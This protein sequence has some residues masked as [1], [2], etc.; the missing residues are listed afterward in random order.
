MGAL[1][2]VVGYYIWVNKHGA[3]MDFARGLITVLFA[4]GTIGIAFM[5]TATAVMAN[6][7]AFDVRFGRG[8]E[9]L[10]MLIGIFGTIL[11]FYFGTAQNLSESRPVITADPVSIEL[12]QGG[13]PRIVKLTFEQRG[14]KIEGNIHFDVTAQTGI[15][16]VFTPTTVKADSSATVQFEVSA[17]DKAAVGETKLRI[18]G[19]PDAGGEIAPCYVT[20]KVLAK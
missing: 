18:V 7:V 17:T 19:T 4:T 11:G 20:V 9:I 1:I 2:Y 16:A 13:E 5:L 8:K 3:P 14:G 15:T 6:D 12:K 10:T